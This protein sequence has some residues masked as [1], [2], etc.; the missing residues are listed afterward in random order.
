MS[1]TYQLEPSLCPDEFLSI[2]VRST[3]NE[4]RPVNEP[5][6][7]AVMLKNA[8]IILAARTEGILVGVARAISD[9]AYCT[10]LSDLAVDEAYQRQGLGKELIR[11]THIAAG[12]HTSLMLLAAPKAREYYP[13][14]G[15]TH[16]DSCWIIARNATNSTPL[17]PNSEQGE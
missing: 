15:M 12:L 13:H 4:R 3:L 14:I 1:V 10:Y 17:K 11:R 16:H 7:I 9:F 8:S 5:E 2:L 6:T